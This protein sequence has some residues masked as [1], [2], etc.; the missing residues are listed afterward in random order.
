MDM[1]AEDFIPNDLVEVDKA[2]CDYYGLNPPAPP[3]GK[4][5]PAPQAPKAAAPANA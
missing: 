4:T 2:I 5:S 1:F 3:S